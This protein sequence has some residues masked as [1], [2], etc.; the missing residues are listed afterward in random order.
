VCNGSYCGT[1]SWRSCLVID[2]WFML[3]LLCA[4]LLE[5]ENRF[6]LPVCDSV[7]VCSLQQ[8]FPYIMM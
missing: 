4:V 5:K 2:L 3:L 6:V 7:D 8:S 1:I